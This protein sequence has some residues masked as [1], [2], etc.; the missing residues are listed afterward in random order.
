MSIGSGVR[1]K[2]YES[3]T[4]N[5]RTRL[6]QSRGYRACVRVRGVSLCRIVK[7]ASRGLEMYDRVESRGEDALHDSSA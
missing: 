1:H 7:D 6:E 2:G 5:E 4:K 3:E